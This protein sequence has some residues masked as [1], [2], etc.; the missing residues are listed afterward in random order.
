MQTRMPYQTAVTS[1]GFESLWG[2]AC[3][4]GSLLST[5]RER[6]LAAVKSSGLRLQDVPEHYKDCL[7]YTSPSPRDRG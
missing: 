3:K 1:F 2:F 5:N 6:H 4:M 7:L